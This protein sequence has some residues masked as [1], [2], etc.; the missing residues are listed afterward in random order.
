MNLD[1]TGTASDDEPGDAQ[2]RPLRDLERGGVLPPLWRLTHRQIPH[3]LSQEEIRKDLALM[4]L[5]PN[6]GLGK[7][8]VLSMTG[9][10]L[11]M[12]LELVQP[13]P[14]SLPHLQMIWKHLQG[15]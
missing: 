3:G 9:F 14:M 10:I 1:L 7:T 11:Q 12:V 13:N 8:H 15:R 5:Q 2:N 6:L 4:T